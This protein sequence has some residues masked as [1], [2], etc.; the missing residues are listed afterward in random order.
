MVA[1]QHL[2]AMT[3][4]A[5]ATEPARIRKL[6]NRQ[7]TRFITFLRNGSCASVWYGIRHDPAGIKVF[8]LVS[9]NNKK[10]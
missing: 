8:T 1:P 9:I 10:K 5:T 7:S 2:P 4:S 3:R 6:P